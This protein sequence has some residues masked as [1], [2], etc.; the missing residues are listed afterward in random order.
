M[1]LEKK[2]IEYVRDIHVDGRMTFIREVI[3][4]EDGVEIA[5]RGIE[6][7]EIFPD[8]DITNKSDYV[9]R[10]AGAVLTDEIKAAWNT[11]KNIGGE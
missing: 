1:A 10:V 2:E 7:V 11:K 6:R 8:T 9:K 4:Y 3:I 5:R